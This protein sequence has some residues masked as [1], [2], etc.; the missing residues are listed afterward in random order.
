MQL[1]KISYYNKHSYFEFIP[2]IRKFISH[3]SLKSNMICYLLNSVGIILYLIYRQNFN[4]F[5]LQISLQCLVIFIYPR[6]FNFYYRE[7]K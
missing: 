4:L 7:K 2:E 1:S 6:V 3:F 5:Q